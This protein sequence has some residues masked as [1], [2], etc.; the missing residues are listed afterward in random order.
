MSNNDDSDRTANIGDPLANISVHAPK[1]APTPRS[2][3][4]YLDSIPTASQSAEWLVDFPS[5]LGDGESVQA[6]TR[7]PIQWVEQID[8]LREKPG[9][10]IPLASL[11]PKRANFYR[12][13]IF[14]GMRKLREIIREEDLADD[15]PVLDTL[16][17]VEQTGGRLS[18]RANVIN[19]ALQRVDTISK[20]TAQLIAIGENTEA[21]SLINQWILGA[22]QLGRNDDS[23]YWENIMA[24]MLVFNP[25]AG[26]VVRHLVN[27]GYITDEYVI[28]IVA[29]QEENTAAQ[30]QFFNALPQ[31]MRDGDS[32]DSQD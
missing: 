28:D 16:L 22:R 14:I 19:D 3:Q 25:T 21:A 17:F 5:S 31:A 13:C 6:Q 10:K 18:A 15:D 32:R 8:E 29:A 7:I 4:T 20:A 24:K 12:W 2:P 23:K 27:L 26:A 9:S 1:T 30:D 11:W